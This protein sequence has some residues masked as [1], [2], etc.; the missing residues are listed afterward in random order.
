M[1]VSRKQVAENRERIVEQAAR[2]FREHGVAGVGVGEI[3]AAAGLTHGG[4][5]RQFDSKDALFAE[6]CA[7]A[8]KDAETQ[9]AVALQ[10]PEGVRAFTQSY[11]RSEHVTGPSRCP[12][13]TLATDATRTGAP[14]QA[15]FAKGLRAFLAGGQG[16]ESGAPNWNETTAAFAAIGAMLMARAVAG[17]DPALAEAIVDAVRP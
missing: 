17:A 10:K 7:V 13:V 5:Y 6:A 14:S 8:L 1:K 15:A 4:F 11:L 3:T 12:M 9:L 16:M 2:L